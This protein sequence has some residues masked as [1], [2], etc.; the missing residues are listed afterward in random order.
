[1]MRCVTIPARQVM[2][3]NAIGPDHLML[4]G[5]SFVASLKG[6]II[7]AWKRPACEH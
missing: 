5:T 6:T 1:M 4:C 3:Y 2:L 7:E